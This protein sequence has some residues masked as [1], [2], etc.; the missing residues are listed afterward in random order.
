MALPNKDQNHTSDSGP[1]R[2]YGSKLWSRIV[3]TD[4][5]SLLHNA[6]TTSNSEN[7][8]TVHKS[9]IFRN[10][11][12][13][14]SVMFDVTIRPETQKDYF[15]IIASQLPNRWAVAF[16]K[17]G[18]RKVIEVNFLEEDDRK[19]ALDTGMVFEQDKIKIL[20]TEALEGEAQ[21]V[22]LSLSHLPFIS[23]LE[24]H[25][26]L[27]STLR[28][29]GKVLDVGISREKD[30]NTYV[31]QGY[32]VLDTFV[33]AD[34]E[35]Q[36]DTLSHNI[37]WRG[38]SSNGFRATWHNM[39]PWCSYCHDDSGTHVART[40]PQKP[41]SQKVTCWH[42]HA[43]GHFKSECPSK[44]PRKTKLTSFTEDAMDTSGEDSAENEASPD[45]SNKG[46]EESKED[47]QLSESYQA[48]EIQS[49]DNSLDMTAIPT[50]LVE[51]DANMTE[52]T[53]IPS[54]NS[55]ENTT[56]PNMSSDPPRVSLLQTRGTPIAI[57]DVHE[58]IAVSNPDNQQKKVKITR[59]GS[60]ITDLD[61]P[62]MS[63]H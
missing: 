36:F 29:Y 17:E 22:R 49:S 14:G 19:H 53:I 10:G 43:V 9:L 25:Q 2:N 13:T 26:G 30:Y 60:T 52:L 15:R 45:N 11:R 56:S 50:G 61:E 6:Q 16:H 37:P 38:S 31:G 39:P 46:K 28:Q 41:E 55:E 47:R 32:A 5:T 59:E 7:G 3:S 18:H 44:K 4:R 12:S 58:Y 40:C 20:P 42:C 23:E 33:P 34:S 57:E 62:G 24:L 54:V 1:A 27:H 51:E 35:T 63:S 21:I 48:G 8:Y